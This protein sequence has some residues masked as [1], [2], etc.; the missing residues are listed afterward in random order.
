MFHFSIKF[1]KQRK[2]EEKIKQKILKIFSYFYQFR[3]QFEYKKQ[4]FRL[5]KKNEKKYYSINILLLGKTQVGK[6]TFINTFL[7]E[8]RAKEGGKGFSVTKKH[9]T[10]HIDNVPLEINDIEGF[11]GEENIKEVVNKIKIMQDK[12]LFEKELHI[13]IYIINYD[14][15]TFF[16]DNEYLIFRQL[17]EK[18][19]N[20]QFLFIC[21]KSKEEVEEEI[22]ENIQES[23]YQMIRKG[24]NEESEEKMM[25]IMK[26]LYYCQKIEI[27]YDEIK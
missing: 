7:R 6:S 10:Y 1:R 18:Y 11:T 27:D 9:F 23:F 17:T 12:I 15:T 13:V 4:L 16:N 21:T 20:T 24:I 14:A 5:Y 25:N 8:K 2:N 26:F 19:D 3:D 22:I